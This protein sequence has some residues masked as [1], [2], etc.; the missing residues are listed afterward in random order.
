MPGPIM[1][2]GN[3]INIENIGENLQPYKIRREN[4]EKKRKDK[5]PKLTSKG[6]IPKRVQVVEHILE[7]TKTTL[8]AKSLSLP[9]TTQAHVTENT[10]TT[11]KTTEA[12][13]DRGVLSQTLTKKSTMDIQCTHGMSLIVFLFSIILSNRNIK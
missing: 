10:P 4:K 1:G 12:A 9:T 8:I 2:E 6:M 3:D 7:V 5:G 11:A 13:E